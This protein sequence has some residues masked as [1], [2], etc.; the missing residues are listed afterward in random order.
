MFETVLSPNAASALGI[1]GQS[2]LLNNAYLADG[3]SLAL[4]LGHRI[5]IDFDFFSSVKFDPVKLAESLK[6]IGKFEIDTAMGITL[7]GAFDD[8]KF[9]TLNTIIPC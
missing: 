1:L 2:G 3:T 5:S 4:R 7:I 6:T 9:S 8:V